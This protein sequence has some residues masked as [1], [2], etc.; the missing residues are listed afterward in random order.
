MQWHNIPSELRALRQWVVSAS[1]EDKAPRTPRTGNLASSVDPKEWGSFEEACSSGYKHIGF[2]FAESDPFAVIDLDNKPNNPASHEELVRHK[3]ILE[4]FAS[5]TEKSVSGTGYHII[6]RGKIPHG[7]NK[8]HVEVYSSGRYMICTGDV[9]RQAPIADYNDL[10]Q[11]MVSEMRPPTPDLTEQDGVMEDWEL[12]EMALNAVNGLKFDDL[13]RGNWQM[14]GYASQSEADFALVSILGFYSRSNEQVRRLFRYSGLG[15][16]EKAMKD[17]KYL[18]YALE[19]VRA[20]QPAII[21]FESL[22]LHEFKLPPAGLQGNWVTPSLATAPIPVT[23]APSAPPAPAPVAIHGMELPAGLVGEIAQYFYQSAVRPVP[24]IALAGALALCAGV[25]G[26]SYNISGMGLNQYL[27]MIAKTGAGKENI[28]TGID[29]MIAAVRPQIPMVDQFIGPSAF[30]SGQALIKI[31]DKKPCFVSVLGEFGLTL[32]QLC[33][34][35]AISAQVMLRK[36][37][38]DLWSKSGWNKMLQSSVY[39]DIEKNTQIIQ[40]PNVTILGES[41]PETFFEGLDASHIS[42]GL[43]PRF[44]IMQYLGHR[45]PRNKNAGHPPSEGLVQRFGDMVAAAL[46]TSNNRSCMAVAT[47][48]AGQGLLDKFD[49]ECDDEINGSAEG[50]VER[51]VWNRGH[52]KAL[53]LGALLAVGVNPHQPAVT[54]DLAEWAIKFV[55][56]D[57]AT[58]VDR[59]KSGDVGAGDSKLGSDLK[60]VITGFYHSPF[61]KV[62]KYGVD[63]KMFKD[64]VVPYAFLIRKTASLAAYRR[65]NRGST[66]ALKSALQDLMDANMLAEVPLIQLMH[67]Y[68]VKGRAFVVGDAWKIK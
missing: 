5:Y 59:F 64:K 6:V 27:I 66:A 36:V 3:K 53:K 21:D 42:D 33:D 35:N 19:K 16:R 12:F 40:S 57:I 52:L 13:C 55:R 68:G 25:V 24:D 37:L 54:Q 62:E 22:K 4:A 34:P 10:L 29:A 2:V 26:R 32:Q 61:E 56:K 48:P 8:D 51:Q 15:Q 49:E 14:M 1:Y 31:L 63:L 67:R 17:D 47:D 7:V 58:M 44:S 20:N 11:T 9:I 41:T 38:L 45:P 23:S 28:A 39:S 65:D 50:D 30:A 18:N 46:T 60:G 43:I